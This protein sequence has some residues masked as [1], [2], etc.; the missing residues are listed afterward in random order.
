MV[1]IISRLKKNESPW[2]KVYFQKKAE[3]GF[4]S[5][6][7]V[8]NLMLLIRL[9]TACLYW[10]SSWSQDLALRSDMGKT[11]RHASLLGWVL[12]P[13]FPWWGWV[14]WDPGALRSFG[15]VSN[16][17]IFIFEVMLLIN[18]LSLWEGTELFPLAPRSLRKVNNYMWVPTLLTKVCVVKAMVFLVVMHAC[19]SWTINKVEHWRIDAFELWCWR[20]LLRV[21]W[22]ARRSIQSP[23]NP[24]GNRPW[25]FIARAWCEEPTHLKSPWFW[26]RLKAGGEGDCRGR[27]DWMAS[28]TQ[29]PWVWANSRRWWRTGRAGLL[30]AMGSQS[31]T[32]LS[33][34]TTTWLWTEWAFMI[35]FSTNGAFVCAQVTEWLCVC[36]GGHILRFT[37]NL[38]SNMD[39]LSFKSH[40]WTVF[41]DI[42]VQV[43][44]HW[45]DGKSGN[46]LMEGDFP[47]GPVA[48]SLKSQ[49]RCPGFNPWSGN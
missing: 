30:Q 19:E 8:F 32:R 15:A 35:F 38:F 41:A 12:E 42:H 20:R 33:D 40:R 47:G 11:F 44:F 16:S 27:D 31:Q 48:K 39:E 21:P 22:T 7:S 46:T 17:W 49:F 1:F 13:G 28:L 18:T 3:L 10:F 2:I 23:V 29:W 14:S 36:V 26:K 45:S 43:S 9:S 5:G 34:W 25:I 4:E 6:S 37:K 24:K